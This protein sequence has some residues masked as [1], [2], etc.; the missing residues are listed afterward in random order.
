MIFMHVFDKL[1]ASRFN[2]NIQ[3]L[4]LLYTRKV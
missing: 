1:H 2:L 3:Q 4:I